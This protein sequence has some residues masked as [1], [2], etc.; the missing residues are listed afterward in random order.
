MFRS[1]M[2]EGWLRWVV[3]FWKCAIK[4]EDF[5]KESLFNKNNFAMLVKVAENYT[6]ID[7]NSYK[8][9]ALWANIAN[10]QKMEIIIGILAEMSTLPSL[11][12][13]IFI[14]HFEQLKYLNNYLSIRTLF[15]PCCICHI[16]MFAILSYCQQPKNVC[17]KKSG[18]DPVGV[19][20]RSVTSMAEVRLQ[21]K[22]DFKK[23]RFKKNEIAKKVTFQN[24]WDCKKVRIQ[25]RN[26]SKQVILQKS[27][28]ARKGRMQ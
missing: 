26:I 6:P 9:K 22:W 28:I 24:K 20:P 21:K 8:K 25:K 4:Q 10:Y 23:V 11:Q 17:V 18:T 3:Q 14:L 12:V 1:Q 13:A 7:W 19:N 16:W 5:L 15:K 2:A 27:E